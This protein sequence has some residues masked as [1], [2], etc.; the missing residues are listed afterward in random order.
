MG[1]GSWLVLGDLGQQLD[2]H[3][4]QDQVER[5]RHSNDQ[6]Q[7]DRKK[8]LEMAEELLELELRHGLLVR[9]LIRK[10]IITAEEYASLIAEAHAKKSES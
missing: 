10:G 4:L 3:D 1:W 7:W 9:L 6:A 8:F 5:I 2:I